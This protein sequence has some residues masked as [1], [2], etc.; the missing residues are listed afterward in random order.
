MSTNEK[1]TSVA[2]ALAAA[3]LTVPRAAGEIQPDCTP[4][5]SAEIHWVE[6]DKLHLNPLSDNI[7]GSDV[8]AALLAS[9]TENDIQSPLIVA[10]V[11]MKVIS[12]NTRLRVAQ[13]LSK[14]KVPVLFVETDLTGEEEQN[15]VL[16]HNVS[17]DKTN[18]IRV[19][20]YECYLDIE[21][22]LAKQRVAAGKKGA[23]TVPNLAPSKS[24][25]V[26]ADKVGGSHSSLETGLKVVKAIDKLTSDGKIQE[27]SRLRKVLNENGY[28]P[29]KNLAVNQGWLVED[30]PKVAKRSKSAALPDPVPAAVLEASFKTDLVKATSLEEQEVPHGGSELAPETVVEGDVLQHCADSQALDGLF[31]AFEEIEAF[32]L[33][34]DVARL[35]EGLKMQI[36]ERLGKINA[37]AICDG[38]TI[39]AS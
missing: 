3:E 21:R 35:S 13:Q 25:N 33:G 34:E 5:L 12:G 4:S 29:A 36:G 32:L 16:S 38:I 8:P 9:I 7:Y 15:L 19:R 18:E 2:D 28:S 17:R 10:K 22:E 30:S 24:R 31:K 27:A 6:P 14:V 20:E 26:A 37:A 11:S 1:T 39:K 23:A